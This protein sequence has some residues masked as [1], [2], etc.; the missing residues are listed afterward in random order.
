MPNGSSRPSVS[1]SS[2]MELT[3]RAAASAWLMGCEPSSSARSASMKLAYRSPNF[4][5]SL[6]SGADAASATIS[7]TAFSA[8]S[9]RIRNVLSRARS[10]GI[11]SA[12][13][14]GR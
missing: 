6:P 12:R 2:G 5:S 1:S 13:A 4:R 14:T 10:A 11:W 3:A 9:A 8:W 7:R